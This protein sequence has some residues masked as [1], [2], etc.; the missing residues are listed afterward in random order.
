MRTSI[1]SLGVVVLRGDGGA[2]APSSASQCSITRCSASGRRLNTR[3]SHSSRSSAPSSAYGVISLAHD[4]RH[5]EPGLDA[6]VQHHRVERRARGRLEAERDVRNAERRQHA[7]QLAL[8]QPNAFDRLDRRVEKFGIAGRQRERRARRRSARPAGAR[9]RPSRCRGCAAAI[10]SLRCAV[11]AIPASS[12][13]SATTA[14]PDFAHQ[15][16]HVVELGAAVLEVDRV[17]DR[18]AGVDL[19]RRFDDRA[20]RSNRSRAALRSTARAVSRSPPS[21]RLRRCARSARCRRRAG[22]RRP[23]PVRARRAR[24]RRSP[25]RAADA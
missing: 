22:A 13:V 21:A 14:A 10:S 18:P 11:F 23:R 12:I 24:S 16:H 5:V 6:V 1:G 20:V 9:T 17:H 3:S 15:R 2:V 25:R 19:Q 4:D 7:G 8:D